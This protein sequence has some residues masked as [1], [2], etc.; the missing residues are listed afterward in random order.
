MAAGASDADDAP[1][2]RGKSGKKKA[3]PEPEPEESDDDDDEE[4]EEAAASAAPYPSVIRRTTHTKKKVMVLCSRGVTSSFVELM[5]DV[6]KLLPHSRKDPKFDKKD[7]LSSIVEIAELAGCHL[8]LYLEARKM[9]DLY[10]WAGKIKGGPSCK[11]LV[12]AVRPLGDLRFTGNCL[13]GSRPVLSFDGGFDAQP[14]LQL[15]KQ[16]LAD[17]FSPPKGHPKSKP[18]HDHVLNFSLLEGRVILRHYQLVPP[19]DKKKDALSLVEIGPRFALV[20][21]RLLSGCFRGDTLFANEAYVSPNM[22]RTAQKRQRAKSTVGHVH[23]K[24]KRRKRINEDGEADMP[25]DEFEE[26]FMD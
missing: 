10:L 26:V 25:A 18:F 19:R 4:E 7:M 12:E 1:P 16:L 11:F 23:Q 3:Q 24:E 2:K 22:A 8:A 15:L 14:H 13:L 21:I 20:P 17:I 6:L 9:K 5:E